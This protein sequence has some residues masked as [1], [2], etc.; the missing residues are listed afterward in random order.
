MRREKVSDATAGVDA[1]R[2]R[3]DG[4]VS[5]SRADAQTVS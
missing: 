4:F 1:P 3:V 2:E 5:N